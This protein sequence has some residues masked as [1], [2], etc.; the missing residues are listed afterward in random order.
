MFLGRVKE[1][2]SKLHRLAVR[3]INV[4]RSILEFKELP[5]RIL[6]GN[7]GGHVAKCDDVDTGRLIERA[8]FGKVPVHMAYHIREARMSCAE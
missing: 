3:F 5:D 1:Q 2:F 7:S 4:D 6:A 8:F